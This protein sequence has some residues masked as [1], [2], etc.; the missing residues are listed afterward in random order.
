MLDTI[1]KDQEKGELEQSECSMDFSR[2]KVGWTEHQHS[3][4]WRNE[5]RGQHS[6]TRTCTEPMGKEEHQT[7]EF[8]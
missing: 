8:V 6:P 3:H 4:P 5:D 1:S 7:K 2:S